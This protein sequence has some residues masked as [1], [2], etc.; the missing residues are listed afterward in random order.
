VL[1]LGE[2]GTG[3]ELVA[4]RLHARS[5]RSDGPFVTL[6]CAAV[7]PDLLTSELFGHVAGAFTGARRAREGRFRRAH[8]GTLFLDEVGELPLELQSALLRVIQERVVDVVGSDH[9][10]PVDVR[11]VCASNRDLR[12]EAA[13]GRFR[14]DLYYRLAVVELVVPPLRDRPEDIPPLV[15]HLVARHGPDGPLRVPDD[16]MAELCRRPWP[17]NVRELENAC[18]RMAILAEGDTVRLEDLPRPS[19]AA[20]SGAWLDHLPDGISLVDLERQAIEHALARTG[21]NVSA[22]SRLLGVPRHILVYRLHKHGIQ[23]R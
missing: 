13:A 15:H 23:R 9:P 14:D 10:T 7:A 2:S 4:R 17:G 3:K 5:A 12:D 22:A 19:A 11:L 20:E 18:E 1:V 16:V 8:G 6:S 21:G